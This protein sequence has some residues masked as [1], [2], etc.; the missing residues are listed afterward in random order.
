M[1][2]KE[3]PEI[4]ERIN[5]LVVAGSLSDLSKFDFSCYNIQCLNIESKELKQII[6][7]KS[8]CKSIDKDQNLLNKISKD[9]DDNEKPFILLPLDFGKK[10]EENILHECFRLILIL[11][12][13]DLKIIGNIEYEVIQNNH[14]NWILYSKYESHLNID[15]K[16]LYYNEEQLEEINEFI[17]LY[18][19]RKKEIKFIQTTINAYISSFYERKIDMSFLSLCIALESIVD[20]NTELSYRIRRNV[21]ILCGK[22]KIFAE[23][24]FKNLNLIYSLRSKIVHAGDYNPEKINQYLPYLQLLISRLIIELILQNITDIK[25]LNYLLTISGFGERDKLTKNSQYKSM[26]I[27]IVSEVSILNTLTK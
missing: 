11:Y 5:F 26:N 25:E 15:D 20:G 27:N 2:K 7:E 19:Q 6:K 23:T 24:I 4:E 8:Y 3:T 18:H 14:L 9:Y 16:Y 1:C 13:C 22:N 21:S 17:L 12:P 10:L